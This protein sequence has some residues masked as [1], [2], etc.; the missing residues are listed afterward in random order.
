[1]R[2]PSGRSVKRAIEHMDLEFRREYSA[3]RKIDL[4]VAVAGSGGV[5]GGKGRPVSQP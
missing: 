2:A 5:L 4:G 3:G 1:M